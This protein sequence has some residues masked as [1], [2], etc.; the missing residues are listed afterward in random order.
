MGEEYLYVLP[1]PHLC[2]SHA[3][4]LLI[5]V[6]AKIGRSLCVQI[7]ARPFDEARMFRVAYA[8]E[9]LTRLRR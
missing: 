4:T 7:V 2:G 6:L 5:A 8:Y 3:C 1:V 9:Q